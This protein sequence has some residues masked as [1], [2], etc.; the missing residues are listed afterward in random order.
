MLHGKNKEKL[1][2]KGYTRGINP[3]PKCN[4]TESESYYKQKRYKNNISSELQYKLTF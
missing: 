2:S 1:L 4:A 3:K